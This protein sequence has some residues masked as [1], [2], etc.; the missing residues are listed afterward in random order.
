MLEML[1]KYRQKYYDELLFAKAK[2]EVVDEI[3]KAEE[4]KAEEVE[5]EETVEEV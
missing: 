4:S 2:V 3:I 1:Y 5:K